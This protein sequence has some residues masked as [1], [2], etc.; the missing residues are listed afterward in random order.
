MSVKARSS[1]CAAPLSGSLSLSGRLAGEDFV[2]LSICDGRV[3]RILGPGP[4]VLS[5][6]QDE[7]KAQLISL[8]RARLSWAQDT[9]SSPA[10]SSPRRG[11]HGPCPFHTDDGRPVGPA[12]V[13]AP[14]LSC[15]ACDGQLPGSHDFVLFVGYNYN[16]GQSGRGARTLATFLHKGSTNVLTLYY[17]VAHKYHTK[18]SPLCFEQQRG[19]DSLLIGCTASESLHVVVS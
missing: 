5:I 1:P 19:L 6:A 4:R 11:R 18:S 16:C 13:G 10:H 17:S 3:Q 12:G 8:S 15:R 2:H 14:N 9:S 7:E